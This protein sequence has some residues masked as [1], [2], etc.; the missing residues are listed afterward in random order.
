MCAL[1]PTTAAAKAQSSFDFPNT[2]IDTA[3]VTSVGAGNRVVVVR[4][5]SPFGDHQE[6]VT[7][8]NRFVTIDGFDAA[9]WPAPGPIYDHRTNELLFTG[10]LC[11]ASLGSFK[12]NGNFTTVATDEFWVVAT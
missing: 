2:S 6:T 1:L 12:G 5:S 8:V 10:L 11:V 9:P 4:C 3:T 7:P